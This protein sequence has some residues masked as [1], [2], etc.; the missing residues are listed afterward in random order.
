MARPGEESLKEIVASI[1]DDLRRFADARKTGEP[2][3][4][5]ALAPIFTMAAS[6]L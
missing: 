3:V 6:R 4:K 1:R 2:L 5:M